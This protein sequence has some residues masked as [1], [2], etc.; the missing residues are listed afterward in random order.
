MKAQQNK[1]K[2]TKQ[3]TI[4]IEKAQQSLR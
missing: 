2:K 3:R 4:K 1:D